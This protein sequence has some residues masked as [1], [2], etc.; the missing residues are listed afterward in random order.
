MFAIYKDLSKIE[1]KKPNNQIG[2]W[3]KE[4]NRQFGKL[5]KN[6][7]LNIRKKCST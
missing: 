3:A 4:M 2:K 6:N 7:L 5:Y 1:G